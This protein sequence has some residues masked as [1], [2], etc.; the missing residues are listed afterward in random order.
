MTSW[1]ASLA[2]TMVLLGTA[3]LGWAAGCDPAGAD[4]PDIADARDAI[5]AACDCAGAPSPGVYKRCAKDTA[6]AT[7]ANPKCLSTVMK[8]ESKTTCGR[9]GA[10]VCCRTSITG[11]TKGKVVR[12]NA[13][14]H[15]PRTG[16]ACVGPGTSVCD[17]CN[18]TGCTRE[19]RCG[20][21]RVDA[22]EQCDTEPF[23]TDD[24]RVRA[25]SCCQGESTCRDSSIFSAAQLF[26]FC[27][28]DAPTRGTCVGGT[29]EPLSVAADQVCCQFDDDDCRTESYSTAEGYHGTT[30]ACLINGGQP[31]I[32]GVCGADQRCHPP[33]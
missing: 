27:N 26:M 23:C 17:A 28:P 11:E 13:H 31:M 12:S 3:P 4:A 10:V 21:F 1:I 22:G 19:P 15:S 14:C 18:A 24:C 5:A 33:D 30:Y 7:L 8:C 2:A 32:G 20:N 25:V 16:S 29:C 9:P 6:R